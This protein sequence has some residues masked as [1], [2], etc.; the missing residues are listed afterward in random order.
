VAKKRNIHFYKNLQ[1]DGN[2]GIPEFGLRK[3]LIA[4]SLKPDH[5]DTKNNRKDRSRLSLARFARAAELSEITGQDNRIHRIRG[6]IAQRAAYRGRL[7][8]HRQERKAMM[9]K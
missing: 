5:E 7:L 6:D 1:Q 4:T 3:T 9:Q 8:S 2:Q